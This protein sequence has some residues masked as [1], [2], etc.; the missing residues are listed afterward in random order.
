MSVNKQIRDLINEYSSRESTFPSSQNYMNSA[1]I[2]LNDNSY[3]GNKKNLLHTSSNRL[4]NKNYNLNILIPTNSL[5]NLGNNIKFKRKIKNINEY[6]GIINSRNLNFN[7]PK[8]L[9]LYNLNKDDNDKIERFRNRPVLNLNFNNYDFSP[10]RTINDEISRRSLIEPGI[11]KATEKLKERNELEQN[12]KNKFY[13]K[14]NNNNNNPINHRTNIFQK[15]E[16][17]DNHE[18]NKFIGEMNKMK[19]RK[20]KQWKKEF[21]EDNNKY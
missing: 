17:R 1:P 3:K 5:S 18:F 2:N 13:L 4:N 19:Q 21:L 15:N 20:I 7:N 6:L 8:D 16:E 10:S 14:I 11:F 12:K 9:F